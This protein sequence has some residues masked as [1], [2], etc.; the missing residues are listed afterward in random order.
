MTAEQLQTKEN[1]IQPQKI[2]GDDKKRK[3]DCTE[4]TGVAELDTNDQ[5][6][7]HKKIC[8]GNLGA[9]PRDL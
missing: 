4:S 8:V 1:G 3:E 6:R 2:A 7:S 5:E 9:C